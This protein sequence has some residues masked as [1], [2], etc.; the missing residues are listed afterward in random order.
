MN[1]TNF[2]PL[3]L[4]L[5]LA[6]FALNLFLVAQR[7]PTPPAPCPK[8]AASDATPTPAGVGSASLQSVPQPTPIN[9][10]RQEVVRMGVLGR[11]R[12]TAYETEEHTRLLFEDADS[13]KELLSYE[14]ADGSL[15]PRLRFKAMHF[16]GLPDPVIVA[17]SLSPG[18]SDSTYEMEAFG[19]VE[20]RLQ[21]LTRTDALTTDE[22]GGFYIGD[23]G[24]GVGLGAAVW[25]D[26]DERGAHHDPHRYKITFYKWNDE[27]VQ[28][29]L[30]KTITTRREFASDKA[31]LRSAGLHFKDVRDG[32][33]ELNFSDE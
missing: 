22:E 20:G 6:A 11:V 9:I 32:V 10:A 18:G 24:Q 28:F 30:N 14:M 12:V 31:A 8:A 7:T 4:S 19:P 25:E 29:E 27:N 13:G 3:R 16:K 23:L 1:R 21:E 17:V 2:R 33:P 5:A 26:L 15:N